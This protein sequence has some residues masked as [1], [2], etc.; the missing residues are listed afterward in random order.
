MG[1]YVVPFAMFGLAVGAIF[2]WGLRVSSLAP[3]EVTPTGVQ[4]CELPGRQLKG[5]T[6]G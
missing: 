5:M 1:G 3:F 2:V 4:R 6:N